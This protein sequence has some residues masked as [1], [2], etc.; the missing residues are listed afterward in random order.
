MSQARTRKVSEDQVVCGRSLVAG[1]WCD[2]AGTPFRAVDPSIGVEI[3]QIFHA[4]TDEDVDEA[5]WQAWEAFFSGADADARAD[6]L[7]AIAS[8]IMALD[9]TLIAM[10]SLETGLGPVRLIAERER[11]VSTLRSFAEL[12]RS[13]AWV[14]ATIDTAEA[15]RRPVPKPDMRSML[16]P[17]GPVGVFPACNF[18]LA[19]S[20]AGGDT[21]SAL[22]AGCPVIVKG[23]PSHPG[24]SELVGRAVSDALERCKLHAGFFSMLQSGGHRAHGVGEAL[25]RH[26]CV[27]AIGFTGSTKGGVSL[28]RIAQG[29]TDPIPV[30]A[31]MGSTNPVFVLEG[32]IEAHADAVGKRLAESVCAS[33]GQ[34]CT[35]PGLIF[36]IRGVA[37]E[38]LTKALSAPLNAAMPE[39]ML[40]PGVRDA[41]IE[42][43]TAISRTPGVEIRG[44][45]PMGGHRESRAGITGHPIRASAVL[46]RTDLATFNKHA[47][48]RDEIFGPAVIQVVCDD[49]A[50]LL[51]AAAS[52]QGSLT[53]TIWAAGHD[54]GLADR[55]QRVL[56]QRV[57]RL[58][59]NGVPTGVEVCESMVHSGPYPATTNDQYTAVGPRSIRR[60]VRP[61]CYQNAPDAFLPAELRNANPLG[62]MR[63]VNGEV[64]DRPVKGR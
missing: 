52:I 25:V 14:D 56:E 36:V 54:G 19:N 64:T 2:A 9:D 53:A 30:F 62:I 27:R 41:F 51:Q 6:L 43:S 23:H 42:R 32:A 20:V 10:A 57:G 38:M 45:S 35:S 61:V 17:I 21:A 29:R 22:A 44:G 48:L 28:T 4:A 1:A 63:K 33:N 34:L 46:F 16:R 37:C 3:A 18:P 13:A 31:E 26:P 8:N 12:I 24:T 47:H 7:E 58:I 5:C 55:L 15:A 39:T 50:A 60:W 59:F 11:T 40:S 49:K